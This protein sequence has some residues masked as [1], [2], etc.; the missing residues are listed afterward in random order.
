[1]CWAVF[2]DDTSLP[3]CDDNVS[4]AIFNDIPSWGTFKTGFDE[5]LWL[6]SYL[7]TLTVQVDALTRGMFREGIL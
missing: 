7:D 5:A 3:V 6:G 1:M 2:D 4:G